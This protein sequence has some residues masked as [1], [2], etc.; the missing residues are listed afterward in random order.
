MHSHLAGTQLSPSAL[1]TIIE[2]GYG[3]VA[4]ASALGE[5]LRLEK[6]SISRLL[7]KLERDGLVNVSTDPSDRRV[8]ALGLTPQGTALLRQVEGYGRRQL[9]SS[10]SKL[11]AEELKDVENGLFSFANALRPHQATSSVPETSLDIREG[12]QSG[13]IAGVT[14]MH[15]AFYSENYRFGAVFERKVASEMS[16][17]MGRIDREGNTT[18]S[19][20]R[21]EQLLGSVTLDGEDLGDSRA[22]LRW[23]I[24]SPNARGLGVGKG[25][26]EKATD[27][28][29]KNGFQQTHLWTFQGLDAARHLYEDAGFR[30]VEEQSGSQ[31]GTQVVEQEF[32][33]NIAS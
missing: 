22:H 31:W 17:F 25:L 10:L 7:K 30:L 11:S 2:L 16:E 23:F 13:L 27:F 15:A 24:V 33:R 14:G 29:D 28:V 9:Q 6:S 20:Y 3:T 32:V 1:H 8:R 12:Y 4:N 21:A 19:A 18:F 26:I 5:L